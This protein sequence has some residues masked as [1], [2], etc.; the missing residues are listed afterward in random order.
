MATAAAP[1][2]CKVVL[3]GLRILFC[4]NR[5]LLSFA[6]VLRKHYG[7]DKATNRQAVGRS[8]VT[9]SPLY[10]YLPFHYLLDN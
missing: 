6:V 9:L 2:R 10:E 5:L 1:P 7:G 3:S 8:S 4:G